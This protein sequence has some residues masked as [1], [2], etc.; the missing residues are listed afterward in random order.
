MMRTLAPL[1]KFTS[2]VLFCLW[3]AGMLRAQTAQSKFHV[4]AF[5]TEK[6]EADHV[7]FARQAVT[8]FA[9]EAKRDNFDWRVTTNWSELNAANLARYQLVVWLNDSPHKPAQRTAFEQ[10]MQHGGAWLGFHFAGYNDSST[11]WSWFSNN[12]LHAVFL[13]NSWPPLPAELTGEDRT[14]PVT[15]G[16]PARYNSPA[17]EWYIWKPDPRASEDIRVL[18]SLSPANYPLGM[19]DTLVS[20]DLPV[21][22]TNMKYRMLYCNMGHGDRIFTSE[23]QNQLIRN[24]ILWLG[25]TAKQTSPK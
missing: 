20:G 22:W 8:F 25:G 3:C 9:E 15:R 7:D 23:I 1:S 19:K 2:L 21:V 12:F 4:L 14:H 10:Y 13:T 24:A 18:V 16:L 5:Y 11:H 17:N 6:T